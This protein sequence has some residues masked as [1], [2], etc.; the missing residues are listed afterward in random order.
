MYSD[1]SLHHCVL[2]HFNSRKRVTE[3]GTDQIPQDL[4][5]SK[6]IEPIQEKTALS[7]TRLVATHDISQYEENPSLLIGTRII[8]DEG[9]TDDSEA[10]YE[11]IGLRMTKGKGVW[12]QVQPA[13]TRDSFE[14][15]A[16]EAISMLQGSK[17]VEE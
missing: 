17:L 3:G 14:I 11:Y 15:E 2:T 4:L 13:G 8:R 12:Y 7:S 1:G 6:G 16:R 10:L 5:N 9:Q